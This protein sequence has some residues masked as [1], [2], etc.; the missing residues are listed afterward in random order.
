MQYFNTILFMLFF[1]IYCYI[2][3]IIYYNN[4]YDYTN[5]YTNNYYD[6][7]N[8]YAVCDNNYI[9][10]NKT[11]Y[12]NKCKVYRKL[13]GLYSLKSSNKIFMIKYFIHSKTKII[14]LFYIYNEVNG[15]KLNC[16]NIGKQTIQKE[17][18]KLSYNI[19]QFNYPGDKFILDKLN[20]T[21]YS[22]YQI[23]ILSIYTIKYIYF[24]L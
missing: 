2:F 3:D 15:Y 23:E 5:D 24:L 9:C 10:F 19:T 22:K 11:N 20:H 8:N 18:S 6:Y 1:Y 16:N 13:N 12:N 17:L 4:Y 14:K 21:T 7:T